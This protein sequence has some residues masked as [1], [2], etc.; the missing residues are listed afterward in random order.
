MRPL[1]HPSL[2]CVHA[3]P[4][5]AY[6]RPKTE[7]ETQPPGERL[8]QGGAENVAIDLESFSHHAS[9]A[10]VTTADVLL[11]ARKNPDLQ[12]LM[13]A[14]VEERQAKAGGASKGGRGRARA[15]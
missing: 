5:R 1:R 12:Q 14:F 11:L 15:A 8:T 10:T 9:R 6:L 4:F 7:T 2:F 13:E 3:P